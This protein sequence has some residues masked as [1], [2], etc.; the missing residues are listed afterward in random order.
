MFGL[1][2]RPPRLPYCG[3]CKTMGERYGQSA[4]MLLNHD[5]VFLAEL[6]L[7][8]GDTPE[9]SNAYRSFNCLSMPKAA[10]IPAALDFSAAAT[11]VLTHYRVEDHR[12]DSGKRRW[13][14]ASRLLSPSYRKAVARLRDWDFPM[15]ALTR[16]LATQ[17]QR[18]AQAESF[19]HVAE[20]TAEATGM[21]FENGARVI[22]RSDLG[23]M[24]H[25]IGHRFGFLI[26]ALDAWE[27]RARD[28][29][30]G[31]FNPLLSIPSVDAKAEIL[32]ATADIEGDI[33]PA[34]AMRLRANV[35]ERLGMRPRVL[36]HRCKKS[37]R[38]RWKDAVGL[39]R[40]IRK[41]EGGLIFAAGCV[42][43]YLVPH[44]MRSAD[45][46][47]HGLGLAMNLMALGT[48]VNSAMPPPP[49]PSGAPPSHG[50]YRPNVA[51]PTGSSGMRSNSG[52]GSG[53][54]CNTCNC[55]CAGECCA[56]GC[57]DACGS[58][59]DCCSG[60]DCG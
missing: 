5:T 38:E 44:H 8:F 42:A 36:M 15:D 23:D 24:M 28:E 9:W 19:A 17:S 59:G 49:P 20:P 50:P 16:I 53:G 56:E 58:C 32:A 26:Y 14:W 57:C 51:I 54:C 55:C 39:A 35:E 40:S 31:N 37:I 7:E 22:G 45:S 6:L 41:K 2:K 25:R 34:L 48:V 11:I 29:K 3:T 18:E 12:V 33:P 1:M 27:D 4:R 60:C 46:L 21:F 10:D 47:H 30:L 13:A 43:A 52:C